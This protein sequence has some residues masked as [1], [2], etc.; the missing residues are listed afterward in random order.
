MSKKLLDSSSSSEDEEEPTQELKINE[1]FAQAF[2]RY[3]EKEEYQKLKNKYGEEVANARLNRNDNEDDD[4]SS[5]DEE[6]DEEGKDWTEDHEKDFFKTL[7]SLKRKDSKLYDGQTSFFSEVEKQYRGSTSQTKTSKDKPMTLIDLERQVITEKG[8]EF[9]ELED[10]N[11][12]GQMRDKTYVQELA[13]IKSSLTKATA[14]S[15]ESDSDEDGFLTK[16]EKSNEEVKKDE[17]DYRSWLSGQKDS[18]KDED[19]EKDL[20]S[21]RE[22]WNDDKLDDGEKFL[23]DYILNQGYLDKDENSDN[24]GNDGEDLSDDEKTLEQQA[25]F[26]HKYNF[27]F[28]EPD[29]DFIKRYPRTIEDSMRRKDDQRKVKRDEVKERKLKEK[30]KK[31]EELKQLKAF[32]RKEILDKIEKLRKITGNDD[33]AFKDEDLED[34]FDPDKYDE[35]MKEVFDHYDSAPVNPEDEEK[36]VFSDMDSDLEFDNWDDYD[37]V[38]KD[39]EEDDDNDNV[40]NY[41]DGYDEEYQDDPQPGTSSKLETQKELIEKSKGRKKS[42]SK[43]SKFE[44]ALESEKPTFDPEDKT[45]DQYLD[46]YYG[47][48]YEDIIDDLPCRFKYRKVAANDLG[49]STEEILSA[50]DRELNA[51]ASLKKTCQYRSDAEEQKDIKE[52]LSKGKN[53]NLKKKILPSL[54]K[55][56]PEDVDELQVKSMYHFVSLLFL[57]LYFNQFHVFAG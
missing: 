24:S 38:H 37:G 8:G 10:E 32:K 31:R 9:D 16:K 50:P 20:K 47:L 46:E 21:L 29:K 57:F 43:K 54:F 48:D 2:N 34:D 36:P 19:T 22:F 6:E 49:L 53:V 13:E 7:A 15:D 52:Y 41:E 17:E 55:E 40:G 51:W 5:S 39:D 14:E 45:F 23:R 33:L 30:E 11:L 56:D 26:E 35:R 42:K 28:E 44:E 4:S 25:E 27:R 12:K 3:R 18:L 1:G